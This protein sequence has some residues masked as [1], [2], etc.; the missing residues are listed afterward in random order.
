MQ[1]L[2]ISISLLINW[3]HRTRWQMYHILNR[4]LRYIQ[5]PLQSITQLAQGTRN[6]HA[7][8]MYLIQSSCRVVRSPILLWPWRCYFSSLFLISCLMFQQVQSRTHCVQLS[9]LS[10]LPQWLTCILWISVLMAWSS[11]CPVAESTAARISFV[12]WIFFSQSM[13]WCLQWQ[14]GKAVPL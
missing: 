12:S 14:K 4:C 10:P 11:P 7:R 9:P 3:G 13:I 5:I 2:V 8:W 6:V 1:Y